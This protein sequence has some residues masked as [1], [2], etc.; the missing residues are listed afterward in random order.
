MQLLESAAKLFIDSLGGEGQG[1]DTSAVTR[2][3]GALLGGGDGQF[4]LGDL[5]GRFSGGDLMSLA[6]SWLGDGA[7]DS[8]SVE[9]I[10]SVLGQSKI[11]EFA[12]G[13][14]IGEGTA[15]DGL[16]KMVPQ[17]ID[18]NSSGGNLLDAVGGTSGL[19]GM[20]SRLFK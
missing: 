9:Q 12:S 16:A 10:V 11:S 1:L 18:Q 6:Q 7:N 3:L 15:S 13:L 8:I 5:V 4:D 19:L 20:A 17:L 2:S 14:G